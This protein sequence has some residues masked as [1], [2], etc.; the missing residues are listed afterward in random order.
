[1]DEV[2]VLWQSSMRSIL[3]WEYCM[4]YDDGLSMV[5]VLMEGGRFIEHT[6]TWYLGRPALTL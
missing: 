4:N 5:I 1:M 3:A 6:A 2:S